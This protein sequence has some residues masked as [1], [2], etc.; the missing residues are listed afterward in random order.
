MSNCTHP[1]SNDAA[2]VAI[3]MHSSGV[4]IGTNN[5]IDH[6]TSLVDASSQLGTD[7]IGHTHMLPRVFPLSSPLDPMEVTQYCI[8]CKRKQFNALCNHSHL[9]IPFCSLFVLGLSL[10]R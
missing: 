8:G 5:N 7:V 2:S 3:P 10:D 6:Q 4:A 1:A 9:V